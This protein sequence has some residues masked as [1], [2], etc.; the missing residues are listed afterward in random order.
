M[1]NKLK[2]IRTKYIIIWI[3]LEISLIVI[4][5]VIFIKLIKKNEFPIYVIFIFIILS[6][7]ITKFIH[8][9]YYNNVVSYFKTYSVNK[10]FIEIENPE[11]HDSY[12]LGYII[13][14]KNKVKINIYKQTFNSKIKIN[15]IISIE[16]E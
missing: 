9:E 6:T 3:L 10:G 16:K 5:S 15:N 2:Q 4:S 13:I 8:K 12:T 11:Y 1:R 14:F 7:Y